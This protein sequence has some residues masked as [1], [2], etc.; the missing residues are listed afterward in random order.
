M[1]KKGTKISQ[2][3]REKVIR[4]SDNHAATMISGKFR[5]SLSAVY[6]IRNEHKHDKE[7]ASTA[8]DIAKDFE[9]II[10]EPAFSSEI[11]DC[12][13]DAMFE[14]MAGTEL[15]HLEIIDRAKATDLFAHLKEEFPELK[16]IEGWKDLK[17][18]TVTT[19][20]VNRLELKA[21]EGKFKGKC[22][23]CPK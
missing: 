16:D 6:K 17:V 14:N 15:A 1:R 22:D 9:K 4:L 20:F 7:L 11:S 3:T 2:E 5:I 23:H 19:S 10:Q 21:H 13:G 12:L 18:N 8:L